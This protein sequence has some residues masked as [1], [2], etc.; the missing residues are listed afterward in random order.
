[1]RSTNLSC[2]DVQTGLQKQTQP[3]SICS[4]PE[5]R[6]QM[7][8]LKSRDPKKKWGHKKLCHRWR[9]IRAGPMSALQAQMDLF[10]QKQR[11]WMQL[12]CFQGQLICPRW[13]WVLTSPWSLCFAQQSLAS[14]GISPSHPQGDQ[15]LSTV[16]GAP[17]SRAT[18]QG[19]VFVYSVHCI[20]PTPEQ[21]DWGTAEMLLTIGQV[22]VP[23][24]TLSSRFFQ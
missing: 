19:E 12:P 7:A 17:V 6:R 2:R 21:L 11:C 10:A 13:C 15:K 9:D 4:V 14:V 20:A 16:W 18:S 8:R 22:T 3:L 24:I 5:L 1:M 23:L